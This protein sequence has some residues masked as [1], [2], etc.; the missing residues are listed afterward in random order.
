MSSPSILDDMEKQKQAFAPVALPVDDTPLD[1]ERAKWEAEFF[2]EYEA[3]I[4]MKVI[5]SH[6][7]GIAIANAAK[8]AINASQSAQR[9]TRHLN[10]DILGI[11]KESRV[12]RL[13]KYLIIGHLIVVALA[14]AAFNTPYIMKS[15]Q[16]TPDIYNTTDVS[17]E[18]LVHTKQRI[19]EDISSL[20]QTKQRIDNDLTSLVRIKQRI[21]EEIGEKLKNAIINGSSSNVELLINT[22]ADVNERYERYDDLTPLYYAIYNGESSIVE[23]LINAGADVNTIYGV[24]VKDKDKYIYDWTPLH[25]AI[26]HKSSSIVELLINAG[27]DVNTIVNIRTPL[28][29]AISIESPTIVELLINAGADVNVIGNNEGWTPLDTACNSGQTSIV[30]LLINA[31]ADVNAKDK[32]NDDWTPLYFARQNGSST[33]VDLLLNAGATE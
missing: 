5:A 27:A 29:Y 7:A 16:T 10:R 28:Y 24:Y 11:S 4:R 6:T 1:E 20:N 33:I 15:I 8:T 14:I 25:Y 31:G 26:N 22:G 9:A 23:L 30:E 2:F 3:E 12:K 21:D 17:T 18:S 19:E 32:E 13:F